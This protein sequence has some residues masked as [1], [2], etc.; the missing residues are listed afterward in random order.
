MSTGPLTLN[1][2]FWTLIFRI[3]IMALSKDKACH[4]QVPKLQ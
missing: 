1:K 3:G 2:E 4:F